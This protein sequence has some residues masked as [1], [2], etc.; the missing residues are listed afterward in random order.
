MFSV[1][2]FLGLG[3]MFFDDETRV[4]LRETRRLIN[5]EMQSASKILYA[6]TKAATEQGSKTT[7][8]KLFKKAFDIS[9]KATTKLIEKIEDGSLSL[10]GKAVG[11]GL[12]E[13]SEEFMTDISKT[14]Y[15]FGAYNKMLGYD[16]TIDSAGAWEHSL[17]RYGMS[18]LGGFLGGGL[19]GIVS[20]TSYNEHVDRDLVTAIRDKK[21]NDLR[22]EVRRRIEKGELG[23]TKLSGKVSGYD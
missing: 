14:L 8:K 11:E 15:E 3:N 1:D 2:R 16:N 12:E 6:G 18:M 19:H 13:V 20:G 5:E 9:K 23:S 21:G 17:E 22:N 4:A 7:P 10:I